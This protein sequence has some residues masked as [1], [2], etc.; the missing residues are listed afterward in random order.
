MNVCYNSSSRDN[1]KELIGGVNLS[2]GQNVKDKGS[3]GF[4]IRNVKSCIMVRQRE[5]WKRE[6]MTE[7]SD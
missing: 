5:E 6:N 2:E 7:Q 3:T 1:L 4:A